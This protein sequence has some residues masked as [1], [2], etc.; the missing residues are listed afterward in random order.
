MNDP[1]WY[2]IDENLATQDHH[3]VDLN[4]ALA[5]TQRY[6]TS[7]R[8]HYESFEE[9]YS[10]TTFGFIRSGKEFIEIGVCSPSEILVKFELP[11]A[12][13]PW[14]IRLLRGP[15][16][17]EETVHSVDALEERVRQ[18][19]NMTPDELRSQLS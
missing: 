9:A 2:S 17:Y 16:Q 1:I 10:Q 3:E 19:F 6:A 8:S 12:D 11:R 14:I 5:I 13:T 15:F 18:F 7:V 4:E